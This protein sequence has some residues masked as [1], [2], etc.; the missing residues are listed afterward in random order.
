MP[1]MATFRINSEILAVRGVERLH[2]Q[3]LALASR[4]E[5]LVQNAVPDQAALVA[6]DARNSVPYSAQPRSP[7][8]LAVL[9]DRTARDL[10]DL[11]KAARKALR[12]EWG[13]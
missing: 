13:D 4:V 1:S 9:Q 12:T 10:A 2:G 7:L 11:I 5:D 8:R 3:L 6:A